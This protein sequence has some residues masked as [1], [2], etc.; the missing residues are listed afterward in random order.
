MDWGL[1]KQPKQNYE[2]NTKLI[3]ITEQSTGTA[4]VQV[5]ASEWDRIAQ[6]TTKVVLT[7]LIQARSDN[8][9]LETRDFYFDYVK[10]DWSMLN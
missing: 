8:R 3:H 9:V 5:T 1:V 4:I 10:N 2:G 7:V 6:P